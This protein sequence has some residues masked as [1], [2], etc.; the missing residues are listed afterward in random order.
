MFIIPIINNN[1]NVQR[2]LQSHNTNDI[3][4]VGVLSL[5]LLAIL[6]YI[7]IDSILHEKYKG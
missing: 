2:I 1:Q 3:I 5:M 7:V 4:V 6:A